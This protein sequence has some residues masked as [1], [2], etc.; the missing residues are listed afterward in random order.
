MGDDNKPRKVLSTSKGK[1]Y[2]YNVYSTLS[3][4]PILVANEKHILSLKYCGGLPLIYDDVMNHCI[5]VL[6]LHNH[7]LK[8]RNIRYNHRNKKW[9][10]NDAIYFYKSILNGDIESNKIG[11]IIDISI[12]DYLAKD[13]IWKTYYK[14]FSV[15]IEFNHLKSEKKIELENPKECY[16][17]GSFTAII[18]HLMKELELVKKFIS[19]LDIN[20]F[21]WVSNPL[22]E[23]FLL[24]FFS[25]FEDYSKEKFVLCFNNSFKTFVDDFVFIC[26]SIGLLVY[27]WPMDDRYIGLSIDNIFLFT[28][29]VINREY[30]NSLNFTWNNLYPSAFDIKIESRNKG[31][32][33]YFGFTLDG[34]GRYLHDNFVVTHNTTELRRF[35]QRYSIAKMKCCCI[36]LIRDTRYHTDKIIT[37]NNEIIDEI[38]IISV[39]EYLEEAEK[40]IDLNSFDVIC[41]DEGQFYPD[42]VEFCNKWVKTKDIIVTC[43]SSDFRR[44]PFKVVANL[45]ATAELITCLTA[46]CEFCTNE[47]YFTLRRTE[48]PNIEL[49]GGK[50]IYSSVCRA[51]YDEHTH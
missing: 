27:E 9:K 42:T 17:Y 2:M 43:L 18:F 15:P 29:N 41:I 48:N 32:E 40:L 25:T 39:K 20:K 3:T 21:K 35:I 19:I 30:L 34:N 26:R 7:Q 50:E 46:I 22:K 33:D 16:N 51:C 45:E 24:G 44:K 4:E 37:H 31:L 8:V 28:Q 12:E 1:G 36:R 11:D 38:P 6:W 47:A 14:G 13:K 49:I 10:K 23:N 5:C